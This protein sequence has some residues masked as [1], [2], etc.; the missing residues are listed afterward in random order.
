MKNS[1]HQQRLDEMEQL[2]LLDPN[3]K[4]HLWWDYWAREGFLNGPCKWNWSF[5]TWLH[6]IEPWQSG[7][8]CS[9]RP[10]VRKLLLA[11]GFTL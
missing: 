7:T 11:I 4:S 3:G 10:A 1:E 6:R 9:T 5:K 2:G 8:H